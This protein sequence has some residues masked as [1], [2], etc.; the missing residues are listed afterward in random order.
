MMEM[1]RKEKI[2]PLGGCL[3]MIVQIP[4]FIALY[5]VLIESVELRQAP[6]VLWIHDLS[7]MDPYFILPVLMG[8]SMF[9]QQKLSPPPPDPAQAKMMMFLPVIMS[10]FFLQAPAGLALYFLTS[11]CAQLL[12]QWWFMKAHG[13]H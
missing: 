13:K 9:M 3:P 6:F 12:Q 4:V 2:N 7:V 11:N 5:Y 10:V 8:L 1:Y